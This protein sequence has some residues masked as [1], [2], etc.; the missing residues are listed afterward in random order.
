MNELLLRDNI[1]AG[2][3][4]RGATTYTI[5]GY[6]TA[7]PALASG[8]F[9]SV[10]ARLAS[11]KEAIEQAREVARLCKGG[12]AVIFIAH[13]LLAAVALLGLSMI[14]GG[15]CYSCCRVG[16]WAEAGSTEQLW[17]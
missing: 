1:V 3:I 7:Y 13:A 14:A 9:E 4:R 16:S 17:G 5:G 10:P 12:A 11:A 15:I 2:P 6:Q 8:N